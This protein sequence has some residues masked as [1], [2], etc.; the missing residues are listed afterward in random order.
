MATEQPSA[1]GLSTNCGPDASGS[2]WS[3][4]RAWVVPAV[5]VVV[6]V[7]LVGGGF[8][9]WDRVAGGGSDPAE[10]VAGDCISEEET[11]SFARRG[12]GGGGGSTVPVKVDCSAPE[13]QYAVLG[14]RPASTGVRVSERPVVC[15][16]FDGATSEMPTDGI[17]DPYLCLGPVDV[18]PSTSVNSIDEG[19]CMVVEGEDARP[20]DC[21]DAGA[22]KVLALF[23]GDFDFTD[24]QLPGEYRE[25]VDAGAYAATEVYSWGLDGQES[26][27]HEKGVCLAPAEGPA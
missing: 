5:L 9:A 16:D 27:D 14:A 1:A 22:M 12:R 19:G 6:L 3:S 20:V 10:I 11:S 4:R 25:C 2:P 13:A 24:E 26:F 17:D 21:A 7:L 8:Y 23:R 18:D 15:T